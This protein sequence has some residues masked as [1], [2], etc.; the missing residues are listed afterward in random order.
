MI[1]VLF[2][3]RPPAA[4]KAAFADLKR[5]RILFMGAEASS[6]PSPAYQIGVLLNFRRRGAPCC[7]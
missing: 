2:R 1:Q 3:I 5:T 7:K 6:E 4:T